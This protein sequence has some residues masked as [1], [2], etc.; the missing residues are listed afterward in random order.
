[1]TDSMLRMLRNIEAGRDI[2]D[3]F[4]GGVSKRGGL[5]KSIKALH[6]R[7]FISI[8][9]DLKFALTGEGRI[10]LGEAEAQSTCLH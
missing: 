8:G 9:T 6:A 5:Q 4:E 1:M 10:I 2:Y 7:G 3:G